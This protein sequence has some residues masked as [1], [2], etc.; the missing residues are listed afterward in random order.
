MPQATETTP[1]QRPI[2]KC[3]SENEL[4]QFNER[5]WLIVE[6]FFPLEKIQAVR[7]GVDELVDALAQRL[8]RAGKIRDL[9]ANAGF[10]SRL[11][12]LERDCPGAAVWIHTA[13]VLKPGL[14]R[15][16]SWTPLL[17]VIEQLIGPEIAGHPVWNLRS[18]TPQN[19]LTTVPWHQDTAYMAAGCENTLQPTAWVPLV[20][21]DNRNGT[22]QVV[23]GGH[24]QGLVRHRLERTIGNKR[25]WYLY[26]DENDLPKGEVV[27]CNMKPGSFLL[28]NQLTPHRSTE[29]LSDG[30]RWSVDLRWQRPDLPSGFEKIKP[31]ILMRSTS[32]PELKPDW[33]NWGKL[34][35]VSAALL[36]EKP[37][38]EW[39]L[40]FDG[41]WME[42]WRN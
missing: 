16:W 4:K 20:D 18:K 35:R 10:N 31:T 34:D 13:G 25:S 36:T 37:K 1:A 19:P 41:P 32:N 22:L 27:T 23:D 11:T 5:G 21:A 42:R 33:E 9:Y 38:D 6:N 3:L 28:I 2:G 29:N 30:I 39:N 17:D 24:R 14:S 12:L 8:L 40:D 26:I 7:D 15:L